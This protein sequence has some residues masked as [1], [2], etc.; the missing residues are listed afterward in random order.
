MLAYLI[1]H[2]LHKQSIRMY[3]RTT[4]LFNRFVHAKTAHSIIRSLRMFYN[5]QNTLLVIVNRQI[6]IFRFRTLKINISAHIGHNDLK[7]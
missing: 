1:M 5:Y 4:A 7:F 3:I 2:K 6:F